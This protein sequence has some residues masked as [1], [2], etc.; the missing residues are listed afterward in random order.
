MKIVITGG[1][2]FLGRLIAERALDRGDSVTLFDIA[3][4]PDG[5]GALEGRAEMI[6]GDIAD[7]EMVARVIEKSDAVVHLAS[8][9]SA[10]SEA[11]FDAAMRVN[12]DGGRAV[13]EAARANGPHTKVLFTS[14][15]AIF[16]SKAMPACV[17]GMTR[18]VPQNTYGM[19]KAVMELLINDMSRKGFID[20]RVGRL[21]TVI[22][23]PGKPNTAAS[24]FASGVIREPLTGDV[25]KL[26]VAREM[27]LCVGGYRT[28][29]DGLMALLDAPAEDF[30][31]DRVVNLPNITTSVNE[32]IAA[33]EAVADRHGISLGAIEDAPDDTIRAIVGSWPI[34]LE[35]SKAIALGCPQD[36]DL[37]TIIEAFVEDYF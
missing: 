6:A 25:C 37:E 13:L 19:T 3:I 32:M 17:D 29:A 5:L 12:I 27:Q 16:G 14:S 36:S 10:G 20:G 1:T 7:T 34:A 8:M 18:P 30:G 23:R 21:P 4:P 15:L 31:D 22:V 28:C 11:D 9:V 35:A 2:G 33:T 24:S 26:P